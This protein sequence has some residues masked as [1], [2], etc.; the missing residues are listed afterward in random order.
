MITKKD[1]LGLKKGLEEKI[2]SSAKTLRKEFKGDIETAVAQVIEFVMKY[3]A[4]KEDL[5]NLATKE[6]LKE[7]E[8]RLSNDIKDVKRQIN[9]LK[10]D[11]PTPQEFA[12]HEKRISKLENAVFPS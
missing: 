5:K 1:L 11:T 8:V 2:E 6:D 12:S 9:D 7:V 4:S 3:A 10:A